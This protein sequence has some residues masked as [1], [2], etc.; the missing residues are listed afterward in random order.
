MGLAWRTVFNQQTIA[1]V[2]LGRCAYILYTEMVSTRA[3]IEICST[4]QVFFLQMYVASCM[5][6][7]C[8][9]LKGTDAG[10]VRVLCR[11][12]TCSAPIQYVK[13]WIEES[14]KV[15]YAP[16]LKPSKLLRHLFLHT[17]VPKA[18]GT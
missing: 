2:F 5:L 6:I 10:L 17:D 12:S 18:D 9:D 15:N 7:R 3:T 11:G 14:T 1:S 16:L 13:L 4:C 8:N